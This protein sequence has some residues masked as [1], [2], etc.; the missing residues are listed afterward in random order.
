M[1]N[2][3][4]LLARVISDLAQ[5]ISSIFLILITILPLAWFGKVNACRSIIFLPALFFMIEL[6]QRTCYWGGIGMWLIIMTILCCSGQFQDWRHLFFN[7]IFSI[8]AWNYL[9]SPWH[10]GSTYESLLAARKSF[11]GPCFTE[12]GILACWT[13]WKQRNGWIFKGI[14]PTFRGWRAS[15]VLE[16]SML[17][18]RM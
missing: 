5:F 9:Q 10:P 11:K 14:R 6:T 2:G 4:A 8:R 18:Y 3:L 15:F 16:I 17:K 12:I 7:C 1:I 13:I